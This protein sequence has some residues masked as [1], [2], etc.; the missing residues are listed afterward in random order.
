MLVVYFSSATGNTENFVDKVGLPSAR[1]P[2]RRTEAPLVVDEPYVLICPTYGGGASLSHE[3]TRPVP[4]QV[5]HFLRDRHN[6]ALLRGVV[7]GGNTNFGPDYA[8]AGD[9]ISRACGVPLLHRFELR[10]DEVDVARVR[11]Q[12]VESAERL[13]LEPLDQ[14]GVD[15]LYARDAAARDEAAQRLARLRLKYS[16]NKNQTPT[17]A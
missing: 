15:T 7:A 1:I 11:S 3:N 13:G 4:P 8:R 10:G 17:S 6:R 14:A 5:E 16:R 2:V 9:E 12:L